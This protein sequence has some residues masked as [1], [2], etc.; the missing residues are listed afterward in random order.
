MDA[1]TI[2]TY[3]QMALEYD[4]E[5]TDFWN[6]F[7]HTIIDTFADATHGRVLDVG[8]G[9]GRDGLILQ[10]K[11]LGIICLDASSAMV[12]LS[13]SRGLESVVG[14][15]CT[16]PFPNESFNGVWA[17]TSLLH[18]PKTQVGTALSEIARVLK[19]GGTFGLGLIEGDDEL[20]R[21]SSG[22]NQPRWFSYYRKVEVE[23]LLRA[24]GFSI[25]Y[26]EQFKPGPRNYLNFISRKD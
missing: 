6:R 26:F 16:L 12:E 2:E 14:D 18:I 3:N 9:P 21:E 17:Y 25:F 13:T 4:A 1:K 8:S 22:K 20:Y 5:T 7:P 10:Q 11:G 24:H 15:L 23:E 19:K